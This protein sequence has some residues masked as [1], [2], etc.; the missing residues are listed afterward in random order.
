MFSL[1]KSMF[2]SL[3]RRPPRILRIPRD[4]YFRQSTS[5][6]AVAACIFASAGA[7]ADAQ[8]IARVGPMPT[9]WYAVGTETGDYAV[10]TD[11][12]RREGGQGQGGGTIHSLTASPESFAA[13][14]QSIQAHEFLGQRVR[15]SGFLRTGEIEM[16]LPAFSSSAGLW[17]RVD[18]A[19]GSESADYMMD[20]PIRQGN[21]WALYEVV[22]DV[23]QRAEGLTFGVIMAGAGQVWLDDVVLERV[24]EEVPLTGGTRVLVGSDALR[25][26]SQRTAYR[27]TPMHPVNL[28]FTLGT[29]GAL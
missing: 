24:G 20:R 12:S 23:P 2:I 3:L 15:L 19:R 21:G 4:W 10:G 17:M 5:F 16:G 13:L 26:R 8:D 7:G 27:S 11:I 6:T 29:R 18:G 28:S 22:L 1:I 9:G 14:Q 25:Q